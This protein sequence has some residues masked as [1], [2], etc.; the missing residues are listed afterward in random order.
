MEILAVSKKGDMFKLDNAGT[1]TWYFISSAVQSFTKNA[2]IGVGEDI[3]IETTKDSKGGADTIVKVTRNSE[4]TGSTQQYTG[5]T[6]KPQAKKPY[7]STTT[8][9]D[10]QIKRLSVSR[11]TAQAVCALTGQ[12]NEDTLLEVIDRVYDTLYKKVS[13]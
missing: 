4:N 6:E 11:A 2:G 8:D 10:E 5:T 12:I 13:G 9:K 3:N 1:P 7:Y